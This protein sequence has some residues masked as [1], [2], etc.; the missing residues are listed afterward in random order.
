MPPNFGTIL[1]DDAKLDVLTF[2]LW[3]NGFPAGTQEMKV[4]PE[5]LET[6]QIVRK[7]ASQIVAN[8]SVVRVVGCLSSGPKNSWILNN[9]TEP[10]LSRDQA[11]TAEEL[12]RAEAIPLGKQRFRLVGA[13][14]FNPQE[15]SG[16]RMDVKGL[17]YKDDEDALINVTSLQTIGS[18]TTP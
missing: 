18:C 17:L 5:V 16:N 13:A 7:G 3:T 9:A 14:G 12:K 2:L 11:S 10:V 8:F 15:N 6:I 4:D 1:T